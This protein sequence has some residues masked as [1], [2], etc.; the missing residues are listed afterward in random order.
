MSAIQPIS[1][2][3]N[4]IVYNEEDAIKI[5]KKFNKNHRKI[6]LIT[7]EIKKNDNFN[8][9]QTLIISGIFALVFSLVAIYLVCTFRSL[10]QRL[11]VNYPLF[12]LVVCLQLLGCLKKIPT[13]SLDSFHAYYNEFKIDNDIYKELEAD[14]E[15]RKYVS[16]DFLTLLQ[17]KYKEG[18]N[19]EF[20]TLLATLIDDSQ[21]EIGNLADA[22]RIILRQPKGIPI[23]PEEGVVDFDKFLA[24][25]GVL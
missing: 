7:D 9:N 23:R 2:K 10:S 21:T 15:K 22:A 3:Y 18:Y 17:R 1:Y 16:L 12:E 20:A 25:A 8:R 13:L 5:L 19:Q 6:I 11:R 24:Q 14:L 4:D